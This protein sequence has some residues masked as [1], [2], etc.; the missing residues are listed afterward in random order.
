ML[1][2]VHVRIASSPQACGGKLPPGHESGLQAAALSWAAG[3]V[4]MAGPCSVESRE[5]ILS[6]KQ[7]AAGARSCAG[8]YKPR[9]S[10][11]SFG[12]GSQGLKLLREEFADQLMIITEVME[13][14]R[15]K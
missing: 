4:M 6:A 5:Q 14:P 7:A 13:S 12:H 11:Y 8:A 2:G 3:V 9:S 1:S 15:S 10:P